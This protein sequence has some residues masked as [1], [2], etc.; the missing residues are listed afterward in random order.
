MNRNHLALFHAVAE[1]G[2]VSGGA[3]RL[4]ISQPAVSKQLGELEEM[5]GVRL[6]DR[7]PRGV[8]LTEGGK[9]LA[10]YSRKITILENDAEHAIAELRGLKRGR[11]A[12][13]A[14]TSVGGYLLPHALIRFHQTHP[15]IEISVETGNTTVIQ[16]ALLE[17]RIEL[18]FT[19]GDR[20]SDELE[21]SVFQRDELV[22]IAPVGHRL[23]AREGGVTAREL[24]REPIIMREVG[25]GTREVVEAAF[26]R[27]KITIKPALS[28]GSTEGIKRVVIGGMGLAIVSRLTVTAELQNRLLDIIPLSD[29]KIVRPLH[30]QY[31]RTRTLGPTAAAFLRMDK[32]V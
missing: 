24:S 6:F 5:L 18:G 11:L 3:E 13:G 20:G 29:L 22:A 7:L 25:S 30:Q 16:A 31:L 23:L 4:H 32:T 2:S 9:L 27:K 10:N 14:S 26:A 15:G 8:R 28:L 12:I 1:A 19:E 21:T 17:G